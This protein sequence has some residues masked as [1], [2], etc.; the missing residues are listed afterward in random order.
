MPE[1]KELPN[2]NTRENLSD[3]VGESSPEL[4]A[5]QMKNEF[6]H[7]RHDGVFDLTEEEIQAIALLR[8]FNA[9]IIE[10]PATMKFCEEYAS[11]TRSRER[12][13]RQEAVTIFRSPLKYVT[14][15]FHAP[16]DE[17]GSGGGF[18]SRF[19]GGK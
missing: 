4:I 19:R 12:A 9:N 3:S 13:G 14:T 10:I 15:A 8:T 16:E 18:W 1:N 6:L 11:L 17:D 5:L 2:G 7:S